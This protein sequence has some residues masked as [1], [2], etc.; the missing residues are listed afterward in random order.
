ML[1]FESHG[2]SRQWLATLSFQ[3]FFL[4]HSKRVP[5]RL[6]I[7]FKKPLDGNLIGR[8]ISMDLYNRN[9]TDA[10]VLNELMEV[11][12]FAYQI[13]LTATIVVFSWNTWHFKFYD[14]YDTISCTPSFCDF[15]RETEINLLISPN[16]KYFRQ[17]L[18]VIGSFMSRKA[19][20]EKIFLESFE[21]W[22]QYFAMYRKKIR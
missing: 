5:V 6:F 9:F 14:V 7:T 15:F 19:T 22:N 18:L 17:I 2:L 20:C 1:I 16:E 12:T 10:S 21:R 13:N 4:P 8:T 11:L 3:T